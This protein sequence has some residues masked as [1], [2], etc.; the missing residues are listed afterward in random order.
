MDRL[1]RL[2]TNLKEGKKMARE[3]YH[4]PIE[5]LSDETKDIHKALGL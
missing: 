3:G 1:K 4:A 2:N 5:E